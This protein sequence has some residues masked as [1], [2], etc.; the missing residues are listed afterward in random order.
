MKREI[1]TITEAF[2][3]QPS[4]Y[5]IGTNMIGGKL[6]KISEEKRTVSGE[7]LDYYIGYDENFKILFECR[8]ESMNVFYK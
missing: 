6:A 7:K 1:E 8:K 5:Q 4:C 2:S 3:M